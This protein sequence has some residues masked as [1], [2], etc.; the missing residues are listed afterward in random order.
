VV[1]NGPHAKANVASEGCDKNKCFEAVRLNVS[2]VCL[3]LKIYNAMIYAR[4]DERMETYPWQELTAPVYETRKTASIKMTSRHETICMKST[5]TLTARTTGPDGSSA[6][7]GKGV[8]RG[9]SSLA[10]G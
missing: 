4:V 7:S 9:V 10:M 8:S 6:S 5:A 2:L 3:S 1:D